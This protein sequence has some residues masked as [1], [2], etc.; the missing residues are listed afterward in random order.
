MAS[1]S[2]LPILLCSDFPI[3]RES[4][5][6]HFDRDGDF[7]LVACENDQSEVLAL[8]AS[9]QPRVVLLDLNIPSEMICNLL[10]GIHAVSLTRI[11]VMADSV[12]NSS[13][14]EALRHGA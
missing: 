8:V 3:F 7:E 2:S 5:Q 11:L 13:A 4:L 14:V 12:D 9:L 10:D 6:A 1:S